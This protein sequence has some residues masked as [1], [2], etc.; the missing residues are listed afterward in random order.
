MCLEKRGDHLFYASHEAALTA[1]QENSQDLLWKFTLPASECVRVLKSLDKFN[2]NAYSL[3]G[4][5]ES[6]MQT[7]AMR[8][9]SP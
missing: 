5:E 2:L 3:F 8:L 4:S 1:N 6:L 9:L 7:M